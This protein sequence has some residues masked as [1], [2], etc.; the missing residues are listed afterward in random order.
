MRP[1]PAEPALRREAAAT[2]GQCRA[3]ADPLGSLGASSPLAIDAH[4][5]GF[6]TLL[7]A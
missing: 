4:P 6:P 1:S 7:R 5:S 2:G 3:G